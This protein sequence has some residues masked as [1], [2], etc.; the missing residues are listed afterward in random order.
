MRA[1]KEIKLLKEDT[2]TADE[3]RERADRAERKVK[4]LEQQLQEATRRVSEEP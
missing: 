4:K 3:E 1:E 2:S